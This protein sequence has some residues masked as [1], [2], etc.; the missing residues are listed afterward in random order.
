M[1]PREALKRYFGYGEAVA[2]VDGEVAVKAE[3]SLM[4]GKAETDD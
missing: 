1:T 4:I 3:L 2:S